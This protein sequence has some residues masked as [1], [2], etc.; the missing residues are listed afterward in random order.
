MTVWTSW[1]NP[2]VR[3]E[4]VAILE[5]AEPWSGTSDGPPSVVHVSQDA[6]PGALRERCIFVGTPFDEFPASPWVDPTPF[7]EPVSPFYNSFEKY[8]CSRSLM[9][10]WLSP[11]AGC[12]LVCTCK[13]DA[14][15]HASPLLKFFH[16]HVPWSPPPPVEVHLDDPEDAERD[17]VAFNPLCDEASVSELWGEIASHI[18]SLPNPVVW[19]VMAG[20]AVITSTSKELGWCTGQPIDVLFDAR[21][22]L[23]SPI[24]VA[25]ILSLI[26]EGRVAILWLGPPCGSFSM[27]CNGTPSTQMRHLHNAAPLLPLPPHRV[28]RVEVGDALAD[29]ASRLFIEQAKSGGVAILE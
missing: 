9:Q 5:F 18:R 3:Q 26:H 6:L 17:E 1:P 13:R 21:M 24:A 4:L 23:L 25:T 10:Q 8:A 16:L 2:A 28:E 11:L 19:E 14:L 29:I 27:A 20:D 15:C 7:L 12:T 22:N